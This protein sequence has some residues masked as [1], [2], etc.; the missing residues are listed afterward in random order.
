[1]PVM[2]A[3]AGNCHVYVHA[4]ADLEMARR[5]R[6]QRQGRP[7]RGLQRGRDAARQR[8]CR[9]RASC[10]GPRRPRRRRGRAGRRRAGAGGRAGTTSVGEADDADWDTEYL[11]MK[12]AVGVVDSLAEA[13]EHVNAHGTGHSE[14]IVTGSDEAAGAVHR[15]R[16][17]RGRLRQ[18]LDPVHRRVRVR[19]GRRDRQLDP[20]AARA[21]A[22]R[23]ARADHDQ[24]RRPRR[25]PGAGVGRS[26]RSAFSGA[27]S[28]RPTSGTS[29]WPRRRHSSSDS[30][31]CCW[32]RP[33]RRRTSAIDPEPGPQVRLEMTR[34]AAAGDELLEVSDLEVEPRGPVLHLPYAGVV[35][36]RAARRRVHLP[37]GADVAAHLEAWREPRRVVE[38]ARLG[39]AAGRD[40]ARRGRG[41][42]RA[43]R[44]DRPR[45]LDPDARDRRLLDRDP[46]ADR[47]RVGR[48]ATWSPE[49]VAELIAERGLYREAVPA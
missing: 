20:E 9:R 34:L 47:R 14:A 15:G 43:A 29:C 3:A 45:G 21:R 13:I 16:R 33:A 2:Y 31:G 28:T 36:R 41:G 39:I 26:V 38:L 4:D 48:S 27:R 10:P 40:R 30:T 37:D 35:A 25:R 8:R 12:M 24:V 5:D 49:A 11:G 6:L 22:D 1:M 7:A 46:A 32:C 44:R 23:P 18:R 19:D 42:A 17:R